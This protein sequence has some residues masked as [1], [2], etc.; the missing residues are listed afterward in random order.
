M[1]VDPSKANLGFGFY[2]RWYTLDPNG[3]Y[4]CEQDI[5][6]RHV[7]CSAVLME[8][9][10][11]GADLGKAGAFSW[12][13]EV[14]E[15]LQASWEK[16]LQHGEVDL[17]GGGSYYWDKEESLWFSWD[18]PETITMKCSMIVDAKRLG[19]VFAWGLGED[20]PRFK[21]LDALTKYVKRSQL[22]QTQYKD[23]L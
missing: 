17:V 2:V 15:H 23:E 21:H 16:A 8:D 18:S 20:A 10:A 11:T 19:G 7:G 3:P 22:G 4:P 6:G 12:H 1:G 13:D 14:P 9:P 5:N